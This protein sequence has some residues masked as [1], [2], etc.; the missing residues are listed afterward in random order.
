M[1]ENVIVVG[2]DDSATARQ[3]V[4]TAAHIARMTGATLHIVTVAKPR[5]I[6]VSDLPAEFRYSTVVN[7]ADNLLHELSMMARE[8]G[9]ESVLHPATGRRPAEVIVRIA[10]QADA[11]LVVV[12]NKGLTG[13]RRF[14]GSVPKAV[15]HD[16]HCSVCIVDTCSPRPVTAGAATRTT[17]F[18][19]ATALEVGAPQGSDV[20]DAA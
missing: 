2:A 16:A 6:P 13:I 8:R 10:K 4:V 7:P 3:A 20:V 1:Y 15:A 9:V 5:S 18:D 12:G 14:F 19:D 11:D 17:T